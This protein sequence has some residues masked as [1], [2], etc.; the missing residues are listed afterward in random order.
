[1][2]IQGRVV[3]KSTADMVAP[4]SGR[5]CVLY[6]ASVSQHRHDGV[7]QPPVAFE[8]SSRDFAIQ[9]E[10]CPEMLLEVNSQDVFPFDMESGRYAS[11][12]ALMDAPDTWRGFMLANLTL[13][14]EGGGLIGQPMN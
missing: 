14:A 4:L 9:L 3:S 7:H 13:G 2:R 12:I 11:E 1:M 10:D 5:S 8:S 6:S